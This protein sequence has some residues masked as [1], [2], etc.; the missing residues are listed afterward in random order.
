MLARVIAAALLVLPSLASAQTVFTVSPQDDLLRFV[1][2]STGTTTGGVPITVPSQIVSQGIALAYDVT[3]NTLFGVVSFPGSMARE[4]VSIDPVTGAAV[5]IGDLGDRFAALTFDLAG[6]M[7]GVTG[8]GGTVPETLYRIDKTTAATTLALALG[9]GTNG[10]VIAFQPKDGLIYHVSGS[11]I[12]NDPLAGPVLEQIDPV[13]LTVTPVTLVGTLPGPIATL[14]RLDATTFFA[15]EQTSQCYTIST[16]GVITALPQVFDHIPKGIAFVPG[17]SSFQSYGTGCPGSG[18]FIPTL[19]GSGTPNPGAQVT[20][21]IANGLGGSTGVILFG[22]GNASAPIV[23]TCL[24][25]IVPLVPGFAVG[26]PLIGA[27]AGGGAIA[28]PA[29]VPASLPPLDIYLQALIADPGVLSGFSS[30][31]P[32]AVHVR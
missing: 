9:N 6:Q 21:A 14:T 1:D 23:P 19:T 28:F 20:V 29:T 4:L 7:Y 25:Q 22:L 18:S 10:E 11:G 3:T 15:C 31:A 24:L 12:L 5:W 13:S 17:P 26:F 16:S 32:L 8:D 2:L 27:G 30:S